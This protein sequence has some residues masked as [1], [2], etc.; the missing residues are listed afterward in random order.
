[1]R[2]IL[3]SLSTIAFCTP[4]SIIASDSTTPIA[5]IADL[6]ARAHKENNYPNI[7][8][9]F[10]PEVIRLVESNTLTTGD[11]FFR[12]ALL[13]G[14]CIEN[15]RSARTCYELTLAAAAKGNIEAKKSVADHWDRLLVT[16]GR[17][18]R[19]DVFGYVSNFP[20]QEKFSLDPAPKVIQ[21]LLRHPT[22][23]LD[24][25]SKATNNPEVQKIV[26]ADQTVRANWDKLSEADMKAVSAN[27]HQRNLRIREIVDTGGLHTARDFANASLVM[28]HSSVFAGYELAHE[29]AVC[30]MLLGAQDTD[31]WLVAATYDRMLNS[32][33]HDQ[34]FGTQHAIAFLG[35]VS[36][37]L[38]PTDETGISDLERI[39]LGCPS[40]AEKRGNLLVSAAWS[41][42]AKV[43]YAKAET[44]A[45]KAVFEQE[46]AYPKGDWR[47]FRS[48]R[49]L[50]V[51]LAG[52]KK[53]SEAEP[54][55][56]NAYAVLKKN[57]PTLS[58]ELK[59]KIRDIADDL[60]KLYEAS[61]QTLKTIEWKQRIQDFNDTSSH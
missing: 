4:A 23:A 37:E 40:L 54:F 42:I 22:E 50:G 12:A 48:L 10:H 39:A 27:D 55:F 3:L 43:E 2:C 58:P 6:E 28:Q 52:E 21:E 26:D 35:Q 20:D 31:L 46:K 60:V 13:A 51:S 30:S 29:L 36:S 53:F 47:V 11:D 1:M 24:A 57:E 7:S 32:I 34:R 8:P 9:S 14:E 61:N 59:G 33:G 41:L 18:M 15:Y 45:R 5:S 19:L 49:A 56:L 44:I 17:P 38:S 25:A 16:L